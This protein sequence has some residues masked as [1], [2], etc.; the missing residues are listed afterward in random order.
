MGK[1][2]DLVIGS[3]LL[4]LLV[5]PDMCLRSVKRVMNKGAHIYVSVLKDRRGSTF[6]SLADNILINHGKQTPLDDIFELGEGDRFEKLMNNHGFRTVWL[7][8]ESINF[9]EAETDH[10]IILRQS[11]FFKSSEPSKQQEM[12]RDLEEALQQMKREQSPHRLNVLSGL[13]RLG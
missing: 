9:V 7:K 2:F 11:F 5:D 12:E 10:P 1:K 8:T 3:L 13:F 4:H 6:I